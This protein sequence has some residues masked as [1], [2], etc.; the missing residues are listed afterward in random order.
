MN[1]CISD[2]ELKLGDRKFC[3]NTVINERIAGVFGVSGAGK[4]TLINIIAGTVAP[5]SGRISFNYRVFFDSAVKYFLPAS[6]RNIGVVFQEHLLFPHLTIRQNLEY[7]RPYLK[8]RKSNI[9]FE[10]VVALL[11][12]QHLLEKHPH[13]LSGGERQRV[14][15]GRTLLSQPEL[16]LMDEPFSN[17][18]RN[19]RGEIISYLLLIN[20]LYDMPLLIVSHDLDDMLKL[21]NFLIVLD[22]G[23]IVGS[24]SYLD[25][26]E[27]GKVP[28][29]I[30]PKSYLNILDLYC[31]GFSDDRLL[32][33]AGLKNGSSSA[34]LQIQFPP[35]MI[36]QPDQ[37]IRIVIIPDDIALSLEVVRNVS[38]Q[39]QIPGRVVRTR[40]EGSTAF[41]L[42]DC[43]FP[44][45]AQITETSRKTLGIDRG[46]DI[47]CLIKAKAVQVIHVFKKK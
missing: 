17:L 5:A 14:A 15:I 20:N 27:S 4:T 13:N 22:Y 16:L 11:D 34:R 36:P 38:I 10:S 1:L 21:T 24:G 39:N 12:I 47:I 43:G 41:L 42:I 28:E 45:L 30:T 29:I 40:T 32:V 18:D 8:N 25:I 26:A 2:V 3:Y 33:Q 6:K 44:L 7:S 9:T 35:G 46:S 31:T 19:R 37:K 23:K